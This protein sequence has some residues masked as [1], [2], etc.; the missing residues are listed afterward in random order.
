MKRRESALSDLFFRPLKRAAPRL[1]FPGPRL[2][3]GATFY[4]PLRGLNLLEKSN[5]VPVAPRSPVLCFYAPNSSWIASAIASAWRRIA[6][7]LSA[8][9]IT[10][11]SG[12]VPE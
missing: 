12:S 10:R 6:S 7:S 5:F 4:C 8:S 3:P 2:T 9:I 11:A 1:L